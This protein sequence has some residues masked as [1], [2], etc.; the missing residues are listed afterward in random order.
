MT[1]R[2]DCKT[3]LLVVATVKTRGGNASAAYRSTK[4]DVKGVALQFAAASGILFL[5]E[6]QHEKN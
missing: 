1:R 2:A 3:H 4:L 5:M 6:K